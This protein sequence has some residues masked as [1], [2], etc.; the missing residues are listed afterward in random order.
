MMRIHESDKENPL[1][2]EARKH[3]PINA[4][5]DHVCVVNCTS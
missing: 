3:E 2:Y 5:L 4:T 1:E